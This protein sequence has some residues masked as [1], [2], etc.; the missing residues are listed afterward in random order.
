MKNSGYSLEQEKTQVA[1]STRLSTELDR[2]KHQPAETLVLRLMKT[3]GDIVL[4]QRVDGGHILR[5]QV[6][7]ER[8]EVG[9]D[10]GS[11]HRLGQND[12]AASCAPVNEDLCRCLAETLSNL[13]DASVVQLVAASQRRVSLDLDVELL[14]QGDKLLALAE[15]MNFDLVDARDNYG[16]LEQMLKVLCAKVGHAD[17]L[18]DAQLLG[19]LKSAP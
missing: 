17:R 10:T 2:A 16:V 1:N 13:A 6:E 11:S 14:A 5:R 4:L 19:G 3:A 18:N 8:V 9:L 12:V 7:V 15:G